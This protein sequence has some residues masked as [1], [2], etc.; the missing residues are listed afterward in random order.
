MRIEQ[1]LPFQCWFVKHRFEQV[2]CW[3]LLRHV[4]VSLFRVVFWEVVLPITDEGEKGGVLFF[5][6]L[7]REDYNRLF[8]NVAETWPDRKRICELNG[9]E[10]LNT[11]SSEF[12]PVKMRKAVQRFSWLLME[13]SLGLGTWWNAMHLHGPLVG[14]WLWIQTLKLALLCRRVLGS[15]PEVVVVFAEMHDLDRMLSW[16]CLRK[17]I[18]CVT[19]QHGLYTEYTQTETVSRLNYQPEF[20]THFLAWGE[21]TSELIKKYNPSV[22]VVICGK[23]DKPTVL[24]SA[25]A[26]PIYDVILIMDQNTFEKENREMLKIL[27][28]VVL[29]SDL[30]LGI[31]FHPQN[32]RDTY[33]T[34]G[35]KVLEPNDN[36]TASCYVGHTTTLLM[37]LLQGG[38]RLCRY[39][40]S[41][42]SLIQDPE[43]EFQ[44]A[45]KL[46]ELLAMKAEKVSWTVEKY[47]FTTGERA[48]ELHHQAIASLI[49]I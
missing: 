29:E 15:S 13:A 1:L 3:K 23:P 49:K 33:D 12:S 19:L 41:A 32:L 9:Y 28:E 17:K 16:F 14:T 11:R 48:V 7:F 27:R 6:S 35:F 42:E 36:A 31:R 25:D 37:D 20:I 46:K 10:I 34:T 43:I 21:N 47:I 8:R 18:P 5:K 4:F 44:T 45:M 26:A 40:S 2:G 30:R 22:N 24:Q 39:A 38:A